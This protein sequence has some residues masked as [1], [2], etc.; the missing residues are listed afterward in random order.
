MLV[1]ASV[2]YLD[3]N[4]G[5]SCIDD[6]LARDRNTGSVGL[7]VCKLGVVSHLLVKGVNLVRPV[8]DTLSWMYSMLLTVSEW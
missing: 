6:F 2:D 4:F 5:L 8:I 3:W 1:C 7:A